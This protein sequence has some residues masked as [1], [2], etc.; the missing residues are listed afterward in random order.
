MSNGAGGVVPSPDESNLS[1]S[2]RF[3]DQAGP[4]PAHRVG[5]LVW[6]GFSLSFGNLKESHEIEDREFNRA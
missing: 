2:R 1:K 5:G 3:K 4:R 6:F